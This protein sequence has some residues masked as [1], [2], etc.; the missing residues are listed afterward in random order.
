MGKPEGRVEKHFVK[1]AKAHGFTVY[2]TRA[3]GTD[4]FPDRTVVGHGETIFVELKAP[5]ETPRKLQR[6]II[7]DINSHGGTAL[8]MDCIEAIDAF[9]SAYPKNTKETE[10]EP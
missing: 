6:L 8:V 10:E 1:Q 7:D 4:G 5:G 2:K 3:I 9:F